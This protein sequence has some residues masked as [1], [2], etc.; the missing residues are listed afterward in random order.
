MDAAPRHISAHEV[1]ASGRYRCPLCGAPTATTEEGDTGWVHCP[2]L[3]DKI[4]C[5][6]CCLDYQS[7]ARSDNFSRHPC[8]EDFDRLSKM[9]NKD[10]TTLRRICMEHQVCVLQAD[11]EQGDE[12]AIERGMHDL[13]FALRTRLKSLGK[14]TND[15]GSSRGIND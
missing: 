14:P 3:D 10:V 4:I 1:D 13:L 5:L 12:P 6:G 15:H 11:L 9:T 8:R 2:M 7:V